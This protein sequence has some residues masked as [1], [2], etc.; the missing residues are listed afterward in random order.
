MPKLKLAVA[1]N[2]EQ[3]SRKGKL[4]EFLKACQTVI[5]VMAE[6]MK[7]E[8]WDYSEWNVVQL[9]EKLEQED[10]DITVRV[11]KTASE[12][13]VCALRV[14]LETTPKKYDFVCI[15][16]PSPHRSKIISDV[17][18]AGMT[19]LYLHGV[20]GLERDI[21]VAS[22]KQFLNIHY[23]VEYQVFESIRCNRWIEAGM[24][25]VTEPC[26]DQEELC[27]PLIKVFN[28]MD[29]FKITLSTKIGIGMGIGVGIIIIFVF[30]FYAVT[31]MKNEKIFLTVKK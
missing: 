1:W 6:G 4:D 13:D 29:F 28:N 19:V 7:L 30:T 18:A 10:I 5:S 23:D 20:R 9:Q 8:I 11:Q 16:S 2:T 25:V 17:R 15:G 14:L 12:Q 24:T 26:V 21:C 22:A 31:K 3:F 27:S